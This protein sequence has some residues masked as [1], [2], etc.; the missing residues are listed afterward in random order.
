MDHLGGEQKWGAQDERHMDE[1]PPSSPQALETQGEGT[2]GERPPGTLRANGQNGGA[3][4]SLGSSLGSAHLVL[5]SLWVQQLELALEQLVI[6]VQWVWHLL[7]HLLLFGGC[8]QA[9]GQLVGSQ[10][11]R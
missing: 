1:H 5:R 4:C 7:H 8:L 11:L 3:H 9:A 2:K 10:H 6:S